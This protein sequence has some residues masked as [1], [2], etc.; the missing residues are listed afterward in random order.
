[1]CI[2]ISPICNVKARLL[3][4]KI[5]KLGILYFLSQQNS[6]VIYLIKVSTPSNILSNSIVALFVITLKLGSNNH[7][8]HFLAHLVNVPIIIWVLVLLS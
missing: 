7:F 4:S 1:M 3:F 6:F 8:H 2:Y 5:I